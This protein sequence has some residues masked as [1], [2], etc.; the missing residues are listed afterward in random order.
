MNLQRTSGFL[1]FS[2]VAK[3][4]SIKLAAQELFKTPAAVSLQIKTLEQRLGFALIERHARGIK[5]S[6]QGQ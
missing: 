3:H 6:S 5:I 1:E 4:G 2:I